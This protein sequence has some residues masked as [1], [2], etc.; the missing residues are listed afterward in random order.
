MLKIRIPPSPPKSLKPNGFRLFYAMT[1]PA[2]QRKASFGK[3]PPDAPLVDEWVN[4]KALPD[5]G[6]LTRGKFGPAASLSRFTCPRRIGAWAC[7]CGRSMRGRYAGP[8]CTCTFRK[9][10][11]SDGSHCYAGDPLS[12]SFSVSSFMSCKRVRRAALIPV[13][14]I[15]NSVRIWRSSSDSS[16]CRRLRR[17]V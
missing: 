1:F 4:L 12:R 10:Q 6:V 15:L 11:I 7:R 9:V 14:L 13:K 3:S 5:P 16:Q 2:S 17:K 8:V